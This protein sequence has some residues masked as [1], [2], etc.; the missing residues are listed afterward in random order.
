VVKIARIDPLR[1]EA[2]LP[3][4][5]FGTIAPGQAVSL[6]LSLEGREVVH[7]ARIERVDPVLDA[8]SGT[9][10]VR[11]QLPNSDAAIPSGLECRMRI[12]H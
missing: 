7:E 4:E 10:A 2:V 9:F 8:A 6:M 1:V 11:L 12:G 3:A 5:R